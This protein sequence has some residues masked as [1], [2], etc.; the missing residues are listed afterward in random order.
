MIEH[1]GGIQQPNP[2]TCCFGR[3][4]P[5]S[6]TLVEGKWEMIKKVS[7]TA[8]FVL[9]VVQIIMLLICIAAGHGL[10]PSEINPMVGPWPDA[11]NWGGAKNGALIVYKGQVHRLF[12]PMLLHAGWIHLGM[13]AA[14]QM[15]MGVYLETVWGIKSWLMVYIGS[16]IWSAMLSTIA[17]P[18]NIGVG[19]SGALM[20]LM[21]GWLA[22]ILC[23]WGQG[24][25]NAQQ[26]QTF[27][28]V[29]VFVN[30][31]V[32]MGFSLVPM[33]D[34]AA[35]LGGLIAG[36]LIGCAIFGVNIENE[37]QRKM[38]RWGGGISL[39][40]LYIISTI[41]IFTNSYDIM[42]MDIC[43]NIRNGPRD[44]PPGMGFT[45]HECPW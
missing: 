12:L 3:V 40:C 45:D 39:G 9:V 21:G 19:A 14:M 7:K 20:G 24:D 41:V 6:Y 42:L 17:M 1:E 34:W 23:T 43:A 37:R 16:G 32:I 10:A 30:V 11:L 26:Q 35:H 31:M 13:N 38:V 28:L 2:H 18:N 22:H 29:M 27:N 5:C 15:R 4:L 36:G 8:S 33:I 44:D 25:E